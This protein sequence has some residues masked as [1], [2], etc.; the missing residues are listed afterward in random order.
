M[1]LRPCIVSLNHIHLYHRVSTDGR[2]YKYWR[3]HGHCV[4]DAY[5]AANTVHTI[6]ITKTITVLIYSSKNT[7]LG[8]CTSKNMC[9]TT[10]DWLMMGLPC[11]ICCYGYHLI[12]K[13]DCFCYHERKPSWQDTNMEWQVMRLLATQELRQILACCLLTNR[14]PLH[15]TS[16]SNES[17]EVTRNILYF[18]QQ[19]FT[20]ILQSIGFRTP[21]AINAVFI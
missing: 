9:A 11:W 12:V 14:I 19:I 2:I 4:G 8:W 6:A 7:F 5:K 3:G 1:L 17:N 15:L 20:Q 21:F 16:F 10:M 13:Q 18:Y